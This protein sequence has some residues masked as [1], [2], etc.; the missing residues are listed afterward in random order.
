MIQPT[1][2][3]AI[4]ALFVAATS[5]CGITPVHQ[6]PVSHDAPIQASAA[7]RAA[8][9][10]HDDPAGR[11]GGTTPCG[12]DIVTAAK[13]VQRDLEPRIEPAPA[14]SLT[15]A[16]VL[17]PATFDLGS[18]KLLARLRVSSHAPPGRHIYALIQRLR[19]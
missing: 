2:I 12:L 17:L 1:A 15:V 11:D 16:I 7:D 9:H 10:H 6:E 19:I 5:P 13:E 8:G 4:A 3:A 14:E 18:L